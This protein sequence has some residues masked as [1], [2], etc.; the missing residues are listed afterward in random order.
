MAQRLVRAKRKVRDARIRLEV[1]FDHLLP[2][3]LS[4]VLAVVYLVFT[5][6][7]TAAP[8]APERRRLCEEAIRLGKLIAG[9]MP[10][11]PEALG[12]VALMLLQDSRTAARYTD[13]G[14]LAL[15]EDQD[16]SRSRRASG[17]ST[18]HCNAEV[19]V[20]TSCRR[21]SR[22]STRSRCAGDLRWV[23]CAAPRGSA[24]YR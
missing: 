7:Y 21:R 4:G 19:P 1:P 22:R 13:T 10:N 14:D 15:L 16:Q 6:G 2:D 3:R 23:G 11:E 20:P 5:Q 18:A 24:P 8:D 17:C 12:L 9:L